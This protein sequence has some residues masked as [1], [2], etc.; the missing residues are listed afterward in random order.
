MKKYASYLP[1]R[2]EHQNTLAFLEE[3]IPG[4]REGVFF[5][6]YY[7]RYGMKAY[8]GDSQ[9]MRVF[10]KEKGKYREIPLTI[11]LDLTQCDKGKLNK[12]TWEWI[13]EMRKKYGKSENMRVKTE[14]CKQSLLEI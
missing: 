12:D 9:T 8:Y 1:I 4:Y 10:E 7:H 3:L 13:K 14:N 11:W 5:S 6:K 2:W